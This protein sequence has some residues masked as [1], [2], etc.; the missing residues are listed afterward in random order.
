MER[1]HPHIATAFV[2]DWHEQ[3]LRFAGVG[4][5]R[6]TV[7]G[8]ICDIDSKALEILGIPLSEQPSGPWRGKTF[9]SL[10]SE[11]F[12][13]KPL[14][15][16]L[17]KAPE[18]RAFETVRAAP[19]LPAQWLRFD[20][21]TSAD[22]ATGESMVYVLVQDITSQRR[23]EEALRASERRFR[24][25][26]ENIPGV[27]YLCKNDARYTMLYL[28]DQVEAVT[29]YPKQRFLSDELSFAELYH[30]DDA[31]GIYKRVD[32]AL[33]KRSPF[34]LVYRIRHPSG[35]WRWIEEHGTGVFDDE[36]GELLFLE[37]FLHD[38][39]ERHR[40]QTALQ[41]S[42]ERHRFLA[43]NSTDIIA[44]LNIDG[45]FAY[46]SPAVKALLGHSPEEM[47]N[48][49][50]YEFVHPE[51]A[52]RM[53]AFHRRIRD[54][55][56]RY[57][58]E[59]R[60]RHADGSYPWLETSLHV[61]TNEL[62]EER[63][64]IAVMR[65]VSERRRMREEIR[66]HAETLET[67]VAQRTAQ[68]HTLEAQSAEMEKLAATGRMAA[69][70]AHEINNPLT[71]I[72]NCLLILARNVPEGHPDRHF[73]ELAQRE[74][75]RIT[76]IVRQMYQ[77]YRPDGIKPSQLRIE[78]EMRDVCMMLERTFARKHLDLRL[79]VS[80]DTPDVTLPAGYLRQILYNLLLNAADA[81]PENGVV[82]FRAKTVNATIEIEV[83]DEGGGIAEDV[84]PRVF[85]PFFTTKSGH[86]GGG[87]GLGLSV[88]RSLATAMNGEL[89]VETCVGLGTTF[90][91]V[92]PVD[93][94]VSRDGGIRP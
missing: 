89:R 70:I 29:G 61:M 15:Q 66:R 7:R 88:S 56:G 2:L 53:R 42:E 19:H 75:E 36:S 52:V 32:Q 30:P 23:T 90:R 92:L 37:G 59:H 33:E 49:S 22:C 45:R 20:A 4:V 26:A 1:S 50:V 35:E 78:N 8:E 82:E 93:A 71:G 77:L 38:I 87:M 76:R 68:L 62:T 51:E 14:F 72:R 12:E 31:E 69:G 10:I 46:V 55:T 64:A 54:K 41:E 28:N 84:L 79:M 44:R 65:D 17:T 3:A 43:Q 27:I 58:L 47:V 60:F 57:N 24:L 73:V 16:V 67:T 18:V 25:L 9:D 34:H 86:G 91:L 13:P 81:S 11:T 94:E 74:I 63:E 48:R 21:Y 85:E 6:C 80:H 39:S 83:A 40:A 5:C